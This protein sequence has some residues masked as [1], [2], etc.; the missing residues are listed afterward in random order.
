MTTLTA[1]TAPRWAD[2][3]HAAMTIGFGLL[4]LALTLLVWPGILATHAA[5]DLPLALSG[6][7]LL[8]GCLL[9]GAVGRA[10]VRT[11]RMH[12]SIPHRV[13]TAAQKHTEELGCLIHELMR[14]ARDLTRAADQK[15]GL[16]RALQL[17]RDGPDN[18]GLAVED[19]VTLRSLVQAIEEQDIPLT[20]TERR[21]A[22]AARHLQQ[23]PG[24]LH[25]LRAGHRII[26][27][28]REAFLALKPA[29]ERTPR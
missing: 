5:L 22:Q 20:P 10:A 23:T 27:V 18:V 19:V 8:L 4:A 24:L 29:R 25:C 21:I 9:V 12:Q 3:L 17:L 11:V 26:C 6:A 14:Q 15:T 7:G 1:S 28:P 2:P 13:A 16:A